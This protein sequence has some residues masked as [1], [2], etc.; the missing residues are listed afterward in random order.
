MKYQDDKTKDSA[1][2]N[3]HKIQNESI[4][5]SQIKNIPYEKTEKGTS[6]RAMNQKNKGKPKEEGNMKRIIDVPKKR[7]KIVAGITL[8]IIIGLI[9]FLPV[10]YLKIKKNQEKSE[11]DTTKTITTTSQKDPIIISVDAMKVFEPAF[12]IN[13]KAKTL[14]Q[15]ELRSTQEFNT[16]TDGLQSSYS[17]FTKAKYDIY[18]LNETSSGE[19]KDFYSTKY[20]SVITINS[21][22]TKFASD[23]MEND[24]DLKK[25]LDL[26][27][28]NTNNLRRNDEV[29]IEQIKKVILPICIIEHTNTN[30]IISVTCP[31][32]L[33]S[34]L[35]NDII[36]AF[37]S[38]KPDSANSINE[39]E[40]LS[41]NKIETKDNKV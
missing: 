20:T 35:K 12:Q 34:N 9:I 1:K 11:E 28:K 14:T 27:I 7:W 21:F 38:I 22:C 29:N 30:I 23:S 18:V 16:M 5:Q 10:Y 31:E 17:T 3:N 8:F 36:L 32:T 2:A 37:Q 15:L 41:G 40:N 33:S 26:N 24:C 19:D 25:Y 39:D 6:G 13:S 4:H